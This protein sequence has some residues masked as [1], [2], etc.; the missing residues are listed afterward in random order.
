MPA[1]FRQGDQ[2]LMIDGEAVTASATELN[3]LDGAGDTVPSGTQAAAIAN[4]ATAGAATAAANATAINS[5]LAA[6]RDFGVI[7]T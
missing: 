4:V 7:A 1:G 2:A 5:M 3:K 6:L